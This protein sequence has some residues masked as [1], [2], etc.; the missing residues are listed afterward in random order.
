MSKER[1]DVIVEIE[2]SEFFDGRVTRVAGMGVTPL[3][4]AAARGGAELAKSR[5]GLR[6]LR[7]DEVS[8]RTTLGRSAIYAL[9]ST[10]DFPK[11]VKLG[12]TARAVAWV[13]TEIDEWIRHR[14]EGRTS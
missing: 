14:M 10:G 5:H 3:A 1:R 8:R 6:L 7:F 12:P 2:A 4:E 11:P 9:I 13:D